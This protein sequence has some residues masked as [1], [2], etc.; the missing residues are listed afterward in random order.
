MTV[1]GLTDDPDYEPPTPKQRTKLDEAWLKNKV[2]AAFAAICV[3]GLT[4]IVALLIIWAC[5]AILRQIAGT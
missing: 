4:L 1:P 5:V 2:S 3:G